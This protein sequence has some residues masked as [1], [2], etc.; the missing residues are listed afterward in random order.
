VAG[1]GST[2]RVELPVRQPGAREA[3]GEDAAL[4]DA[5]RAGYGVEA[6]RWDD[7]EPTALNPPGDAA[8]EL[9]VVDDNA[10]MREYLARRLGDR[11]AVRTAIDG[12]DALTKLRERA[13]DL[14]LT[15]VMMPRMDG[16]ALLERLRQDPRTRRLPVIMLSARAGEEAVVEGLGAGAD[17]YLSSRSRPPSCWLACTPT[18]KSCGCAT[19]WPR[20]SASAPGRSRTSR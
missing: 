17:D 11:Y 18:W 10:D 14:V 7:R 15:D 4:R 6:L 16:F 3:G 8:A 9:L 13:A 5:Q 2:F 1:Q 20:A 19:R 12:E